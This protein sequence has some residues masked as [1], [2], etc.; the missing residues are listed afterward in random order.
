VTGMGAV[1]LLV[2]TL[3]PGAAPQEL[4]DG[5]A[6]RETYVRVGSSTIRALCTVGPRRVILLHGADA[7]ADTWLPVLERL[8]GEV[9]ACAYDR[10]GYGSS[11]PAPAARGWFELL[12]EMR[13]IHAALGVDPGYT[14]VG[15]QLSGLY[16]R[17]FAA[18]RPLDVGGLVL[19]DPSHEDLPKADRPGMP[20]E[21][22]RAWMQR[23]ALVNAD[24]VKERD[25]AERARGSALPDIPVTVITAGRRR[26]GDGWDERF[27]N[28]AARRTHASIL[29]GIT[30]SR[31]I[32]ASHSGPDVQND[33]PDLVAAEVLRVV[34]VTEG[35]T[36]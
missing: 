20:E 13:R 33:Q 12:D 1:A 36:P 8:S 16:A 30:L 6:I 14:L 26:H 15:A 32:P 28:E 18:E 23:R 2:V 17:L 21:E 7:T 9:G 34:R 24:G 31:H 11:T 22:W 4:S 25:V 3:S 10:R 5:P 19:V 35:T 27:L 29:K